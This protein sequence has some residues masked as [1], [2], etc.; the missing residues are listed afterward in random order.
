MVRESIEPRAGTALVAILI[1]RRVESML[2][3]DYLVSYDWAYGEEY[4]Y[5]QLARP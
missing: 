3:G 5:Y 2:P 1:V 4:S